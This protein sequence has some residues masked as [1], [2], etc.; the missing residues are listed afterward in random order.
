VKETRRYISQSLAVATAAQM[1]EYIATAKANRAWVAWHEENLTKAQE[2]GRAAL[3]LWQ[4]MPLV[5][6]FRWT[7]LWPLIG[8]ALAENRTADA[9]EHARSLLEVTQQRLPDRLTG[10]LEEAISAWEGG[11]PQRAHACLNESIEV[12]QEMG[13]L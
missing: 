3:E 6:P 5:Y 11:E 7:A 10:Q 2:N 12:A 9:V 8:V 4:Q 13:N 1:L